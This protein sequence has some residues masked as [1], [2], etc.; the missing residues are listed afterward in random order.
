M[1]D[2]LDDVLS[3]LRISGA[4][5]LHEQYAPPWAIDVPSGAELRAALG[6]GASERAM[7]FHLVRK[8]GF[9]FIFPGATTH[10]GADHVAVCAGGS[11]HRMASGKPKRVS[12]LTEI[13]SGAGPKP[14]AGEAEGATE[15]VCGVFILRAALLNP[16]LASLP[17]LLTVAT[18]GEGV[19]PVL[20]RAAEVLALD[21]ARGGGRN[22]F[23]RARIVEIFCAETFRG[24]LTRNAPTI[25]WG[26]VL[27]DRRLCTA[28]T[29]IHESPGA[30][31]TVAALAECASL[32]PSRFA[33]RF[34][35]SMG[36]SVLAYVSRW[37]MNVAGRMLRE[38]NRS[39]A[40]IAHLTGYA[41]APPFI[42]AF[43]SATGVSPTV[44]R[45]LDS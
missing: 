30:P 41:S 42:R 15:L 19:D 40:E 21:L 2:L 37:R 35:K 31:W 9:D 16:L 24:H 6:L 8:G 26:A 39:I 27:Q 32:S 38:T 7:P 22:G 34:R 3:D 12:K 44:W 23:T 11:A 29:K 25:G 36:Q 33:A 5:L 28:L 10:V 14:P 18:A 43:K 13:L 20:N 45:G 17:P 1:V 4:V